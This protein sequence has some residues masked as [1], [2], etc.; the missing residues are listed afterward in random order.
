MRRILTLRPGMSFCS[1]ASCS[2]T[3][4]SGNSARKSRFVFWRFLGMGESVILCYMKQF[5]GMGSSR[6]QGCQGSI[7]KKGKMSQTFWRVQIQKPYRWNVSA[8]G[9]IWCDEQ[10][11]TNRRYP[12]CFRK[13]NKILST[14]FVSGVFCGNGTV[15]MVLLA[16]LRF[17]EKAVLFRFLWKSG[18]AKT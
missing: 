3:V 13:G 12:D 2:T 7:H 16:V 6:D 10:K 11:T 1:L 15:W 9:F 14:R 5:D 18:Q 17:S 8:T 4:W